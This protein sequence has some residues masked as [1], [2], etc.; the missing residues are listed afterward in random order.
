MRG[1]VA[2]EGAGRGGGASSVG[3]PV[4]DALKRRNEARLG[5]LL[6]CQ[7]SGLLRQRRIESC[8]EWHRIWIRRETHTI[9]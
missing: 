9:T 1:I 7:G 3:P 4:D 6:T 8:F 5:D 2:R